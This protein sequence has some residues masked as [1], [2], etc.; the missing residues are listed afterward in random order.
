[1]S[2]LDKKHIL[3]INLDDS[4]IEYSNKIK[5]YNTDKNI[6]NLYVKIKKINND[7]VTVDLNET[8]LKGLTLKLIA[9]KP[10]TNQFREITGVLTKELTEYTCAIYKFELSSEFTNQIGIVYAQFN[11]SDGLENGEDVTIDPFTYEIRASKL[12]G[13]NAE[14]ISNPDLPIL[15]QLIKEVQKTNYIDDTNISKFYAYSNEKV[16]NIIKNYKTSVDEQFI[17]KVSKGEIKSSDFQTENDSDKIK[18]INLADEVKQAMAGDTPINASVDGKTLTEEKYARNSISIQHIDMFDFGKNLF[19]KTTIVSGYIGFWDGNVNS[20]ATYFSSDFI[21]ISPNE[22]YYLNNPLLTHF[23]FYDENKKWIDITGTWTNSLPKPF[24]TPSNT[25]Y[26]RFTLMKTDKDVIQLEKGGGNTVYEDFRRILSKDVNVASNITLKIPKTL[27]IAVGRTVELYNKQI[28]F[29]GNTD[30]LHF[31]YVCSKGKT[32]KRKWTYSPTSGEVGSYSMTI[33]VYDNN[34]NLVA[35]T[36]TTIKVVNKGT[37]ISTPK[38][39]LCIGDSLT[40]DKQW[41]WEVPELFKSMYGSYVVELVGSRG[42][43]IYKHEGRSGY[44]SYMYVTDS[45][46][47]YQ[48]NYRITVS[49]ITN[50]PVSKKRYNIP[51]TTGGTGIFEVETCNITG[52]SG[53]ID[54]NRISGGGDVNINGTITGIDSGVVGDS[55]ITYTNATCISYNPFWNKSTSQVDFDYYKATTGVNTVDICQIFLGTNDIN[56]GYTAIQTRDWIKRLNDAVIKTYN[57]KVQIVLIPYFGNQDGLGKQFGTNALDIKRRKAVFEQH[58][59]IIEQ[60]E[61]DSNVSITWVGQTHDSEYN[62]GKVEEKV[63]PRSSITESVPIEAT[64]PQTEGYLQMADT[65]FSNLL[66]LIQ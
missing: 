46:Y 14:I 7:E 10:K 57:C 13:L 26:M 24:T 49:G 62:F 18:L 20:H 38:K 56:A 66:D 1:M 44:T 45:S 53:T 63:N 60:F 37:T 64:H 21:P 41:I 15:R 58:K 36:T 42:S 29:T 51:L 30:N 61:N 28:C 65:I 47:S 8:D 23:A 27:C 17:S 9:I 40:N 33:N 16:D 22:Q 2:I 4:S 39:V 54:F 25:Y 43:G 11:L 12:T 52:G 55:S 31:E 32:M 5:F 34:I 3:T 19:N 59:A 50:I 48:G 35:T 6:S